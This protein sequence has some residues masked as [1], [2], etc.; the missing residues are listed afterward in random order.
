MS[1]YILAGRRA[2]AVVLWPVRAFARQRSRPHDIDQV[3][4]RSETWPLRTVTRTPTSH[5]PPSRV[6]LVLKMLCLSPLSLSRFVSVSLSFPLALPFSVPVLSVCVQ[7]S[8]PPFLCFYLPLALP[9]SLPVLSLRP[10]IPLT[11]LSSIPLASSLPPNPS[12]SR[13]LS[14]TAGKVEVLLL[15]R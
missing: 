1:T 5:R 3:S 15:S 7:P 13:V 10:P 9:F 8:L 12:L 11:S 2:S 14:V 6:Y 4:E